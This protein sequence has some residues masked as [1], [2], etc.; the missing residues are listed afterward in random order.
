MQ[1][2][3]GDPRYSVT[4]RGYDELPSLS[5]LAHDLTRTA[6]DCMLAYT[7]HLSSLIVARTLR[8]AA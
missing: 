7:H 1:S 4:A 2:N 6:G 3:F 5:L 8:N